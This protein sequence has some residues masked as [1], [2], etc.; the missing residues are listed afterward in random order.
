MNDGNE[1]PIVYEHMESVCCQKVRIALAEKGIDYEP[2][3]VALEAGEQLEP[4]FLALNPSG[5][6]PVLVHDGRTITESSI[7]NEYLDDAFPGP[8]LMPAE[9]YWRARRRLWARRIDE[10]M[11]IPHIATI[12]FVIAFNEAFR[13][14]F[15]TQQKL[16]AYLDSI[17][18]EKHRETL[19]ASF[20][21]D[22]HGEP[23]RRAIDAY[24]GFLAELDEQLAETPW[25]AG[26]EYSLADIDVVPYVWRL[27]N[28]GLEG[29]WVAR[30]RVA[31]W[32]E[33]VTSRP[34]FRSA[35]VDCALGPWI[36]LMARTGEQAWPVVRA[37]LP[38]AAAPAS[39]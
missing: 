15:D 8:A 10:E 22:L 14:A 3:L 30:P 23:F 27:R 9:P 31:D 37:L 26:P 4:G 7:I 2:R 36:E 21:S 39:R 25:L 33:R 11:H 12:S 16:D 18:G 28:L 38:A 32:L 19:R 13:H 29:M 6:V 17:P 20:G 1:R 24:A 5:V 34:A 35:V